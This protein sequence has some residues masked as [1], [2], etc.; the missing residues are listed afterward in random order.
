MH[1][2]SLSPDDGAGSLSVMETL[3][4]IEMAARGGA[5]ALLAL[6]AIVVAR[7]HWHQAA[8]RAVVLLAATVAC[9]LVAI[10]PGPAFGNWALNVPIEMGAAAVPGAFWLLARSWFEDRPRLGRTALA[11][12]GASALLPILHTYWA[13]RVG[14]A[15]PWVTGVLFRIVMF[16]FAATGLLIAWRGRED[17]LLEPRRRLRAALVGLVGLYVVLVNVLEIAIFQFGVPYELRSLLVVGITL[18]CLGFAVVILDLRSPELFGPPK[19]RRPA[20]PRDGDAEAMVALAARLAALMAAEKPWR[21]ERLTIGTLAARLGVPEHRLRPLINQ[22]LGHRNF[23]AYLNGFRLAEVKAALADPAQRDVPVVT[24][25]LDAGFGSLA[26]FNRAF[27][28]S[29]GMTPSEYR[30]KALAD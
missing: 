18:L 9:H 4:S 16:A 15:A 8:A 30:Q 20:G 28:E 12:V 24:V 19:V 5:L 17:D 2:R 21:D 22:H 23:A 25:A 11:L 10:L 13:L 1:R 7:G 3:A 29:E 14:G 27:R 26:P 6:L